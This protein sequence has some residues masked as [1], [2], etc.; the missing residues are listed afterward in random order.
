MFGPDYGYDALELIILAT[1]ALVAIIA[2]FTPIILVTL[3]ILKRSS[4]RKTTKD[5]EIQLIRDLHAG[6]S[7]MERRIESLETILLDRG[8]RPR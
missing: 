7:A 5:E 3:A 4:K 6:L 8:K 1:L 2:F